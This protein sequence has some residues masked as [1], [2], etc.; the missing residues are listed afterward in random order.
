VVLDLSN[1]TTDTIFYAVALSNLGT[2]VAGTDF[3]F[4][5]FNDT[6]LPNTAGPI[7]LTIPLINNGTAQEDRFFIVTLGNISGANAGTLSSSTVFIL[8]DDQVA[9]AR[10][11]EL[12][13]ALATS[14]LVDGNGSAEIVAYDSA[15]QR[16]F[17]LNS[18]ATKVEILNFSNPKNISSIASVDMTSYGQGATSV[19]VHNGIVA[20][21]IDGGVAAN[22]KVV[23]MDINGTILNNLTVGNLP[24]MVTF[25]P[26]GQY[27]LTANEGQPDNNY[28]SDPEGSVS[29]ID[30]SGGVANVTQSNVTTADF[31]SFNAQLNSLKAAGVRIF[32]LNSSVA[33][34]V[35]PEYIAVAAD[36]QTAWVTLQENNAVATIDLVTKTITAITPLGTKDHSL[37][38]QG[39]DAS[40]RSDSIVMANYPIRGMYM[41]DAMAVYT[42]NGVDY[43]VTA[44]EGDQ[45]EY[46][47]I[48]EDVTIGAAGYVLDPTTFPDAALLKQ[49]HLLGR[50]AASP[51]SGDTDN[52]GDFDEIHV[53]GSRSFSIWNAA[54]GVLV[55][56]SGDDFERVTATDPIFGSLFNASNSN[57]NF[58]NRSDN[59]GPE[60]E[61]VAVAEINNNVYAFIT[62]E[63]T[64]GMMVYNITNPTAPV[65]VD[66]V[67]SRDL[68]PNDGGDLGPEG[69]IYISAEQSPTDTAL[70]VIANEVSATLSVYSLNN[71]VSGIGLNDAP[72]VKVLSAYPN[73]TRQGKVVLSEN[74]SFA[75]YGLNG[76]LVAR[77][78]NTN[79]LDLSGQPAGLYLLIATDGRSLKLMVD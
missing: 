60:P 9:P 24:D 48:D 1:T 2:A 78:E 75:V 13:I 69:I 30:I 49:Q 25:T 12:D 22:G 77:G 70:V 71:V 63:R 47:V 61:G 56:D 73:P 55:F 44:N 23:F 6:I 64:G 10:T 42:V 58:K 57:N 15:S 34:D 29:I 59:K 14:Y 33:Q 21:T 32:G 41:P 53:F 26:N 36:N 38:G 18:T 5:G 3:T 20:A 28:L 79:T 76:Q 45:R 72:T 68:G 65:L 50:L 46:G 7:S 52:D 37:A 35:E 40:D 17:V 31:T 54:T 39:L 16:L 27:V 51:Y 8:D 4:S 67:N 74:I 62:L 19:A 11:K 43:L 66:Y